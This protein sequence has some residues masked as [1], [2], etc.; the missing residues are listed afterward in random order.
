M[1]RLQEKMS[2]EQIVLTTYHQ[3]P[4]KLVPLDVAQTEKLIWLME[5]EQTVLDGMNLKVMY[6]PTVVKLLH[7]QELTN[8]VYKTVSELK[9][10]TSMMNVDQAT[11]IETV[12][13]Y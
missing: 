3:Y 2:K 9:M 6:A 12:I 1:E 4:V 11:Q 10:V 7:Q 8:G 13:V 5:K